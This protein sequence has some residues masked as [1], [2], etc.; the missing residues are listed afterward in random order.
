MP[1]PLKR[2]RSAA[3]AAATDGEAAEPTP[4]PRRQCPPPSP[5][6][7]WPPCYRLEYSASDALPEFLRGS[8]QQGRAAIIDAVHIAN[9]D[10][11]DRLLEAAAKV[12]AALPSS[13]PSSCCLHYSL[14]L[15]GR[16]DEAVRKLLDFLERAAR[17]GEQGGRG[18]SRRCSVLV[19]SGGGDLAKRPKKQLCSLEALERVAAARRLSSVPPPLPAIYVAFNPYFP[20]AEERQ[21]ERERLKRK[22]ATGLIAPTGGVALQFGSDAALLAEALAWLRQDDVLGPQGTIL[23]SV[24]LPTKRFLAAM[25]F[26]PWR[27]VFLSSSSG[28]GG[29]GS[30]YLDSVEAAEKCTVAL[31]ELYARHGVVPLV[32]T[33][34]TDAP[35]LAA[36][37]ALLRR[38]AAG[39][40]QG[41]AGG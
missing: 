23:G 27:G 19:V 8:S 32:E 40:A 12:A 2:P 28:G 37:E 13:S 24:F 25:R 33:A 39:G 41:D 21:R 26:R 11:G 29:S 18:G 4:A 36:A 17:L 38:G 15:Q 7:P 9:K 1:P 35:G 22:L 20:D 34:I 6:A 16:G 5:A 10:K 31:L 14:K 3:A 30:G